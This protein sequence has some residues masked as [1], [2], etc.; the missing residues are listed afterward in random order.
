MKFRRVN[1]ERTH[2]LF[3]Y[4]FVYLK[5]KMNQ[6]GESLPNFIFAV[7]NLDHRY[8]EEIP[9]LAAIFSRHGEQFGGRPIRFYSESACVNCI[10]LRYERVFN[11]ARKVATSATHIKVIARIICIAHSPHLF[12][13]KSRI[14]P[15]CSP[16]REKN[17]RRRYWNFGISVSISVI[18]TQ[19]FWKRGELMVN[20]DLTILL[21]RWTEVKTWGG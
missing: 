16:C 7:V 18:L 9:K 4:Y 1:L 13:A 15:N 19:L 10:F 12:S 21:K 2:V 8:R 5:V 20:L 14:P 6:L 3:F 17:L 11:R